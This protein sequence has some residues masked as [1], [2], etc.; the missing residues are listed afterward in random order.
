M[1]T[2][3]NLKIGILTYSLINAHLKPLENLVKIIEEISNNLIVIQSY[4][5]NFND[6]T[7]NYKKTTKIV[8]IT[9]NPGNSFVGRSVGFFYQQL[10]ISYYLMLLKEVNI[11]F[12]N[13]GDILVIPMITA[14]L[15]RKKTIVII[16]GNLEKEV[17]YMHNPLIIKL[18]IFTKKLVLK[19]STKILL[20]SPGL[21][22][23][24][25][26]ENYDNKIVITHRHFLDFNK[27]KIKS[28]YKDRNNIIGLIGRLSDEKGVINFITA[29]KLLEKRNIEKKYNIHFLIVGSGPL[30]EKTKHEIKDLNSNVELINWVPNEKLPNILNQLKLL[31]IPSFTEGL[32]NIMLESMACGTPILSNS[33]GAIPDIIKDG[34]NGFLM[35]NNDP[36]TIME[37]MIEILNKKDVEKV[38]NNADLFIKK[39]F[40]FQICVNNYSIILNE[41]S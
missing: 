15:F 11:W 13:M 8:K 19:L 12:F 21:V 7:S 6:I 24:W 32:P 23:T 33:V 22:K 40:N 25:G 4:N 38:I 3:K 1:I 10:T 2:K 39:N 29:I 14:W 17:E 26:L 34:E 20:Y 31:V 37:K 5:K 9:N 16:G 28:I 18:L 35:E 30:Y 41:I 27:F 36:E